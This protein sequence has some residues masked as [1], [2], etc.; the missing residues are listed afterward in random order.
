M[1]Y[2]LVL[3]STCTAVAGIVLFAGI[4]V[5]A[6]DEPLAPGTNEFYAKRVVPILQN[7]CLKCHDDTAKGGLQLDSYSLIR[8][9][10]QDGPVIMPG[11]LEASMLIQA[12]RRSGDLKMPP[13]Y[14]LKDTEVADLEAWVKAGAVGADLPPQTLA[15][16]AKDSSNP[17]QSVPAANAALPTSK[18]ASVEVDTDFFE[19]KVRPIFA[20]NC[21]EC[22][23][24]QASGGM[25]LDSKGAFDQGGGRGPLIVPG[26]PDKSLLIQAVKQSGTLEDA[27]R[28][29]AFR[30]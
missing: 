28:W 3:G 11:D 19:N 27:Q 20:N 4:K 12:I 8:K 24:D 18:N 9:G 6:S 21:Y 13:K 2:L 23:T 14:A 7:N 10:G 17:S 5:S 22:H 30:R 15:V 29:Q 16:S 25:R 26:N 1:R